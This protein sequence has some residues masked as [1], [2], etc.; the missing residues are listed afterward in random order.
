MSLTR[1]QAR[2]RAQKRADAYASTRWDSTAGGEIDNLMTYV[3]DREWRRILTHNPEYR[4]RKYS[5]TSDATTGRWAISDLS[6]GTGDTLERLFRIQLFMVNER[7]YEQVPAK[8][9]QGLESYQPQTFPYIYWRE[10]DYLATLPVDKSTVA[11]V[12]VNHIPQKVDTLTTDSIAII[13]PDGYEEIY[14]LET[15]ALM[16]SKGGAETQAAGE[17][18]VLANQMRSDMLDEIA[19]WSGKPLR[20]G[21]D[22]NAVDWGG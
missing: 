3:V 9:F 8:N 7:A 15:A 14:I 5:I 16:L 11:T 21:Y 17:L 19:R 6:Y 12:W 10:G 18:R 2:T 22:D 4:M 20:M 13:F 1:T